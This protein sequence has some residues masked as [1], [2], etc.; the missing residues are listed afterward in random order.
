MAGFGQTSLQGSNPRVVGVD[1]KDGTA[2]LECVGDHIRGTTL[3]CGWL[4]IPQSDKALRVVDNEA[5]RCEICLLGWDSEGKHVHNRGRRQEGFIA[6]AIARFL[7]GGG[8][9][10]AR[11]NCLEGDS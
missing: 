9:L 3:P 10:A 6:L 4:A 11:D 7:E 1:L 2:T 5:T 8:V